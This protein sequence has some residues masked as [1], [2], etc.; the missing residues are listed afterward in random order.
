[1]NLQGIT[2]VFIM[3]IDKLYIYVTYFEGETEIPT[4]TVLN[5]Y[6]NCNNDNDENNSDININNKKY[7]L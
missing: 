7:T 6:H 4:S 5:N 1:M 3:I 2:F